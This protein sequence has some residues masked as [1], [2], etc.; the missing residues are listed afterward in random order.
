MHNIPREWVWVFC[1]YPHQINNRTGTWKRFF[2]SILGRKIYEKYIKFCVVVLLHNCWRFFWWKMIFL[3][4]LTPGFSMWDT[5]WPMQHAKC[6]WWNS[7]KWSE[8][9]LWCFFPVA[10][11]V[12]KWELSDKLKNIFFF[13]QFQTI[14]SYFYSSSLNS[15]VSFSQCTF[16]FIYCNLYRR[17]RFDLSLHHWRYTSS[18][19]ACSTFNIKKSLV[20][21]SKFS[22]DCEFFLHIHI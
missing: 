5:I 8:R 17:T 10:L 2:T 1:V 4:S 6:I 12:T 21:I 18:S 7:S 22:L 14:F 11:C 13:R 3:H 19:G 20:Y 16:Y 15:A 9:F